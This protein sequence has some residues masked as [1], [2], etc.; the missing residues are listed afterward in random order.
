[1]A[2]AQKPGGGC[3]PGSQN[4]P[5]G[6]S[7]RAERPGALTRPRRPPPGSRH[8]V[9]RVGMAAASG[10]HWTPPRGA[11]KP[12]AR[13]AAAL[14]SQ[15]APRA[16]ARPRDPGRRPAALSRLGTRAVAARASGNDSPGS[17]RRRPQRASGPRR[18]LQLPTCSAARPPRRGRGSSDRGRSCWERS[19]RRRCF[20]EAASVSGRY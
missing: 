19:A 20:E 4:Q 2:P 11:A 3:G 5:P 18:A 14:L 7:Q 10:A 17:S 9:P 6:L 16:L 13:A 8:A 15:S 1:M 12:P